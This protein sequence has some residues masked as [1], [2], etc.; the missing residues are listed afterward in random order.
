M[1]SKWGQLPDVERLSERVIRI[2]GGNPGKVRTYAAALRL[3]NRVLMLVLDS[4]PFKVRRVPMETTM[5]SLF[6]AQIHIWLA[7][8]LSGS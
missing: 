7:R 5:S 2:L 1:A 8:A 3:E 6:K 4:L